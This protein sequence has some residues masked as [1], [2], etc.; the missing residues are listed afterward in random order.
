M[1]ASETTKTYLLVLRNFYFVLR[2]ITINTWK[3]QNLLYPNLSFWTLFF[4]FTPINLWVA[5]SIFQYSYLCP[6]THMSAAILCSNIFLFSTISHSGFY[7]G[8]SAPCRK[9]HRICMTTSVTAKTSS[10][11]SNFHL[12]E[13]NPTI[14]TWKV[15]LLRCFLFQFSIRTGNHW[16]KEVYK[17]LSLDYQCL[18]SSSLS[19]V[20]CST[21]S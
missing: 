7:S 6:F 15:T 13:K 21:P 5:V 1:F 12:S 17:V 11:H 3:T 14:Q 2:I 10:S 20:P 16:H 8:F 18:S 9:T 4:K 19:V